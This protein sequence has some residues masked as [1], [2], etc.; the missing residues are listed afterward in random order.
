MVGAEGE[1]F[2]NWVSKIAGNST[3][4]VFFGKCMEPPIP[5]N[6]IKTAEIGILIQF[7]ACISTMV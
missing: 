1:I 4:E 7:M 3:F 6:V 5:K 2:E